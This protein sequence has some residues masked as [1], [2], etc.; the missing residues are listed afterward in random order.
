MIDRATK[1]RGDGDGDGDGDGGA[2]HPPPRHAGA[3]LAP[4]R[5]AAPL[6]IPLYQLFV[7]VLGVLAPTVSSGRRAATDRPTDRPSAAACVFHIFPPVA[8]TFV[9]IIVDV[10]SV[11]VIPTN[12]SSE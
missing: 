5:T 9:V 4:S 3:L 12:Y 8:T 6:Y 10:V 7:F 1:N 11:S 2:G